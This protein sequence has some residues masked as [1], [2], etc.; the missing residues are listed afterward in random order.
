MKK[1]FV[2]MALLAA[3]AVLSASAVMA[4][5]TE[6]AE[7]NSLDDWLDGRT[8]WVEISAAGKLRPGPSL[9]EHTT[10]EQQV[11]DILAHSSGKYF[12]AT[13]IN[14]KVLSL[15]GKKVSTVLETGR[16]IATSLAE[17]RDGTVYVAAA[18]GGEIYRISPNGTS[19]LFSELEDEYVWTLAVGTDGTLYAGTG[20]KGMIY[21]IG[22]DGE[23]ETVKELENDQVVRL[24]VSASGKLYAGTAKKG[25]LYEIDPSHDYAFTALASFPDW[26]LSG[27]AV[28]RDGSLVVGLNS[29]KIRAKKPE[30]IKKE[31]KKDGDGNNAHDGGDRN[32]AEHPS[33]ALARAKCQVIRVTPMGLAEVLFQQKKMFISELAVTPGGR[34]IFTTGPEGRVLAISEHNEISLLNDLPE[35]QASALSVRNGELSAV[36]TANP[37]VVYTVEKGR[38]TDAEYIS[39][40]LD[41]KAPSDWGRLNW[42][43]EGGGKLLGGL[44]VSTRSGNVERPDDS[45][46]EWEKVG[47]NGELIKSPSARYIRVKMEWKRDTTVVRSLRVYYRPVNQSPQVYDVDMR[48]RKKS[49]RRSSGDE[50]LIKWKVRNPDDDELGYRL[51]Y[52]REESG[53]WLPVNENLLKDDDYKWDTSNVPDGWY[54]L[55]VVAT[56]E[57][58]NPAGREKTSRYTTEPFL[59]DN[60]KPEIMDL[61]YHGG[62]VSGV[63]EDSFSVI[64]NIS[65][66]VDGGQWKAI[67]PEDGFLDQTKEKFKIELDNLT[68]EPHEISVMAEDEAGNTGIGSISVTLD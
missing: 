55:R 20:P 27:L 18:P 15:D 64:E 23:A 24:A 17:G 60:R 42:R 50:L 10:G 59:V 49:R 66:S 16:V 56:D 39:E 67:W 40:V 48:R 68:R 51:E 34:I 29:L 8:T 65:Y 13:G 9:K 5:T 32:S 30:L 45:W 54:R 26:E 52:K 31:G 53:V 6:Y 36:A 58:S 35:S 22:R 12:I 3:W 43:S 21:A 4:V 33:R 62:V 25:I 46:S 28:A 7:L 19:G 61:K 47:G 38:G 63:A 2:S 37:G 1:I 44:N 14:G 11:W 57:V 41:V